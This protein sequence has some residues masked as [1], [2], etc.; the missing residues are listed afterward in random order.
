MNDTAQP[1]FRLLRAY[2]F[3]VRMVWWLLSGL[4][5]LLLG[6]WASLHF[7]IVPR[8]DDLRPA[9]ETQASRVL[10]ISVRIGE[11]QARFEGIVPTFEAGE[12]SLYDRE[13]RE[14]LRLPRV[15]VSLSPRSLFD[16]GFDQL[17]IEQPELD[18][19]RTVSG[20]IVVAGLDMDSSTEDDGRLSSWFFRQREVVILGGTL[21]WTDEM[22]GAPPLALNRVDLVVR[23]SA[24]RH[25]L[26][27][28]ATPSADWG[29]RF[30]LRGRFRQP[31]LSI[32]PGRW[33]EWSGEVYGEFPSVDLAQLM[34]HLPLDVNVQAGH[35]A[36]RL[37]SDVD[38][39]R[40]AGAV[41]D[42][43]LA[44]VVARLG[45][46]LEPLALRHM[47]GRL[48]GQRL[49]GGF[50]INTS[51]LQFATEDGLQWPG[52]NVSLTWTGAEARIA[53]QGDLR[54]DRLDLAALARVAARLPLGD[55]LHE[56]VAAYAPAGLVE[57]LQLRW[58]GP[59]A[60]PRS[61]SVRGRASG[62][63]I[64]ARPAPARASASGAHEVGGPGLRGATVDFEADQSGGRARLLVERGALEFPGV[65]EE[66]VVPMDRL[67]ADLSWSGKNDQWKLSFA[68]LRFANADMQ[69]QAQGQWRTADAATSPARSR[70]PGV[71]DL[72]GEL[73]RADGARVYRYLPQV[74]ARPAREYLR[75]AVP[76]AQVTQARFRVR[77]DIY[78]LP[79]AD[80]RQGEFSVQAKVANATYAYVPRSVQGAGVKPWPAFTQLSADLV[81]DRQSLQIKGARGRVAGQPTLQLLRADARIP[82]LSHV[83][84]DVNGELR[85]TVPEVLDLIRSTPVSGFTSQ[86][87]DRASGNGAAEV[88]LA[89]SVPLDELDRTRVQGGVLLS[90]AALQVSADAPPLSRL[91][92]TINFSESGFSLAGVQA[93]MYGGDA[94]IEG[95]SRSVPASSTEAPIWFRAQGVASAEGLRQAH[96][97]GFV[98]RLAQRMQGSTTYSASL[99]FRRDI[100]E[101][102]VTSNLQGLQV[103]LP[104][105]LNKAADAALPLRYENALTRESLAPAAR[106][107]E[108]LNVE[109]GRLAAF[110][111][112]RDLEGAE[113]RVTRGSIAIGLEGAETVPLAEQGV[114][115][116][117]RLG[118][119]DADAWERAL[120]GASGAPV[121][122]DAADSNAALAYLPNSLALRAR[123]LTVGGRTLN[124]VV[125]GGVRAGRVWRANVDADELSGYLEYRQP[126]G[127]SPG[128]VYA[129]LARML[130]SSSAESGVESLLD[131]EPA[132]VPALDVVVDRLQLRN[133][134]LGRLE[135]DAVN[136]PGSPQAGGTDW[137]LNRLSL[138]LPEAQ[139]SASGQ[140]GGAS[141]SQSGAAGARA[142][143]R[144]T[145]M[146]FQ[147]DIADSGALL[148]RLGQPGAIRGGKGRLEGQVAW[149]GSPLSFD[150]PSMNGAFSVAIESGQFLKAEPGIAKLLGVLSLQSLPR[151]LVLDFRDV[152]SEGFVF[153]FVRG[154]VTIQQGIAS[155]NNLQMKGVNAAVLMDGRTDIA[156]ETQSIRVV[157]VPEINAGT[158]SLVAATINPVVGLGSFLAQL[159]LRNPL[160]KAATQEFQIEGSWSDPRISRVERRIDAAP[161]NNPGQ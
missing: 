3:V 1:R 92:G 52:G 141:P 142:A 149:R 7:F 37:W 113:P 35:G 148:E 49:A 80:A 110:T 124:N 85:G 121:T 57:S 79:F 159:F 71:L 12:V 122:G 38:Q 46:Q 84:V 111:Y 145:Q 63:S 60:Q 55:P 31:L 81:I 26:R 104:A 94:R 51:G 151:R 8:I 2:A 152:F 128:R 102:S 119:V 161:G 74:I 123:Q 150:Y 24:R 59:L 98:A 87:L 109:L 146:N 90:N 89:L 156:R 66:P 54:A 103:D 58:Q 61:F 132:D 29:A 99:G 32:D 15:V 23:N 135:I 28:D 125:S 41:A 36:L 21:R 44:K 39:G 83:V 130:I 160:I 138:S 117:I 14:A 40:F 155:T 101:V 64:A 96:E 18:V 69:G 158:A 68:N 147:L 97:L 144:R 153:D 34:R 67:S 47:S 76:R 50:A 62:L 116:N 42:V 108:Q 25:E 56:A 6:V 107:I 118:T 43:E 53:E 86:V 157:V 154:D 70:F 139:F 140:W 9:L 33:Q 19:R 65:F 4:A 13:G 17:Y 45:D 127:N 82:D 114:A 136:L 72:S 126:L 5:L 143:R 134:Q 115:A 22:R 75:E 73:A 93:R 137:R 91:R 88:K 120:S 95:G 10:G 16:L 106:R 100:P 133:L 129:R 27:L 77:G 30:S 131:I 48:G 78:D 105:P 20:H 11:I 112:L